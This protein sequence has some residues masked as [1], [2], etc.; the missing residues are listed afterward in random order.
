M[1]RSLSVFCLLSCISIVSFAQL[2]INYDYRSESNPYYWKN[3][4]PHAA[5]WQQDVN[6]TIKAALDDKTDIISA[7]EVLTYWNNSPDTLKFVY[8]HLYQNA[9]Q[10]GSY[11]TELN[12]N[13]RQ[14]PVFGHYEAEG[15]G[16]K[17]EKI[18]IDGQQ[19][20]TE[21]DNT[22]LK[23][24]LP[25][26][27]LPGG[28]VSFEINFKTYFDTGSLRRRMKKFT[29]AR[30][31]KHF[32]AVHWYPRICVYDAKF[33]W[34]TDQHLGKEFYGDFGAYQVEL[35]LPNNYILDATGEL[36]NRAEMLPA[37]LRAKLDISNFKNK[38]LGEAPSVIIAPDGTTKTWK[39]SAVNVHDFAFTADPT[40]R[41]GETE[42]NGIKCIALA[43]EP[44]AAGWQDAAQLTAKVIKI[45]SED[46]GMYA[47]PKMIVADARDGMEYPML[48]LDGGISPG[49]RN[50]IAHEI[51]HNWFFGMVGNN[52]TYRAALDEGFTQ[53]LTAWS[54]TRM[55][56]DT[57]NIDPTI[58]EYVCFAGYLRDAINKSDEPLNTHS[59]QF[60][61]ALGHG[62]GYGHVYYKTA[63][64]LYNLQYVLGDELFLRAMK[65]YVKQYQICHPY[66]ED[67]RNSIIQYT[68]TDLNWF[69]DQWLE[70]TKRIDYA[71]KS[72]KK[73]NAADEYRITFKRKERMQMPVDFTVIAKD[74]KEYS[75]HIPNT[76][77]IKSTT[78]TV[79]PMWKGWDKIYP[80]YT[81]TVSIPGG[82]RDV[83]I[84]TTYRLADAYKLDNSSKCPHVIKFNNGRIRPVNYKKYQSQWRPDVWYNSLDGIKAGLQ[85]D[86][87]FMNYKHILDVGVWYNTGV[88][89]DN[90]VVG[91]QPERDLI[92]WHFSYRNA[93][94]KNAF[95]NILS[96][97]MDGL[98]A[99]G[100]SIEKT[101]GSN[102]ISA[103]FKSL[104]RYGA[105]D[106]AYLL[107]QD[108]WNPVM[109]NN[110][111][112]LSAQH[113]YDSRAGHGY[114]KLA[115]KSTAP[116]SDYDY[117]NAN[118]T[119]INN[120]ALWKFDLRTR[121]FAQYTTGSNV[122]PESQLY[123]AGANPEELME[124][125]YTRS[126]GYVPT[127]WLG[128]GTDYNHF[129]A[130]GG[131][132]LRGFSGYLLPVDDANGNQAFS[133]AG[134]S[135]AAVN[136]EL[137]FDRLIRFRPPVIRN[138][139]KLDTYLF[140]DLGIMGDP[141]RKTG[142]APM[143][144][145]MDAGVGTA[146][147]IKSW[148]RFQSAQPLTLR[149]DMPLV[150]SHTPFL[151]PEFVQ[152]RWVVGI[153]RAF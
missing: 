139:L 10:P 11:Y 144:L 78:A 49:Y 103:G 82:I 71:V 131:L 25:N 64:M 114:V 90:R 56:A 115:M 36:I 112:N 44:N 31:Y 146:L 32:D 33:G 21:L 6:Y 37:D 125:K 72:V 143:N 110:T 52:E 141:T 152:F 14:P 28:K 60:N 105:D 79:L 116:G 57:G 147:T 136:M 108:Q 94:G 150:L 19:V 47:Y 129:H 9:F 7:S 23:V 124:S 67:F 87:H 91:I 126:R 84:D 70:T 76:Y 53:F 140:G 46:F 148:G 16:T 5:Y 59:D 130:G 1:I 102:K 149:F 38:P 128:Y 119:V 96:R 62:G 113:N 142:L 43:Q 127:E 99:H 26:T 145:R 51:G 97:H 61:A 39:F 48:T 58:K 107:Y 50:V 30:G 153:S 93:I 69:F 80:E 106:L 75:Y 74:G 123:M 41:I 83:R 101:M 85:Y 118:L 98:Y 22:I 86:G 121:F 88:F 73:G 89:A 8:F 133:Y 95:Y 100:I 137:D 63:T 40:Y 120:K 77:F 4:K 66:F 29:P 12:K 3:R 68:H 17:V 13:N 134:R 35:T 92:S 55:A 34:E 117:A 24:Y 111:L 81:A 65:N 104:Y 109:F 135:G 122:A 45:Y 2:T 42:W 151:S 132:N 18:T 54:L 20:K 27:L 138:Y 15:M